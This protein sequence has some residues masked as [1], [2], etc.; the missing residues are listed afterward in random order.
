METEIKII[1]Y[2][3]LTTES[4]GSLWVDINVLKE[5]PRLP[6]TEFDI[7]AL[8]EMAESIKAYGIVE[9]ILIEEISGEGLCIIAGSRR[10][11]AAKIAGLKKVP[12]RFR[13]ASVSKE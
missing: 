9:P 10:V 11:Q 4:D 5:N 7:D 12:V 2:V 3:C 1:P 6:Q 13:K 8:N